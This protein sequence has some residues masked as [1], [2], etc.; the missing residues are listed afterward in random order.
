[1]TCRIC[2]R[3]S[4]TQS[5][6]SLEEQEKYEVALDAYND[7]DDIK[8]ENRKCQKELEDQIELLETEIEDAYDKAR[9]KRQEIE[10]S[11]DEE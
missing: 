5:F 11:E 4:C 3:G 10:D 6:H 8:E 7:A 1:M 9:E 2:A